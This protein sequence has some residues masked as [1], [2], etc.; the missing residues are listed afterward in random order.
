MNDSSRAVSE[1]SEAVGLYPGINWPN[2]VEMFKIAWDASLMQKESP[3]KTEKR[4]LSVLRKHRRVESIP[5]RETVAKHPLQNQNE[6]LRARGYINKLSCSSS[7]NFIDYSRNI[8]RRSNSLQYITT[9]SGE[10]ALAKG[11]LHPIDRIVINFIRR[12]SI[13]DGKEKEGTCSLPTK[14]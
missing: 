1:I 12:E 3:L 4:I 5:E 7:M 13:K 10:E 6:Y 14:V 9:S 2:L 11:Q 8:E